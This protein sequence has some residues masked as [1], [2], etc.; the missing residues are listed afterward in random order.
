MTSEI[1]TVFLPFSHW[2]ILFIFVAGFEFLNQSIIELFGLEAKS[3]HNRLI[4]LVFS[5]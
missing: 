2:H 3:L 5:M 4:M 1:L